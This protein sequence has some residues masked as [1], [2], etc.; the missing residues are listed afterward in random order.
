M[1][2]L[3]PTASINY[4]CGPWHKLNH[5]LLYDTDVNWHWPWGSNMA[6]K[7]ARKGLEQEA[8]PLTLL[9]LRPSKEMSI[10]LGKGLNALV[11][12]RNLL[13]DSTLTRLCSQ[14]SAIGTSGQ[15]WELG[16]S[17]NGACLHI[18]KGNAQNGRRYL[19]NCL[20]S[21]GVTCKQC[22]RP[23]RAITLGS[24]CCFHNHLDM[25]GRKQ[26]VYVKCPFLHGPQP[27]IFGR[28]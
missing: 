8:T 21:E 13:C 28:R 11:S 5:P 4:P 24:A 16:S 23:L 26:E 12:W 9:Q 17:G 6:V 18:T 27:L 14:I 19:R 22:T 15:Q 2:R 1:P 3:L 7:E 20:I 10:E 25:F